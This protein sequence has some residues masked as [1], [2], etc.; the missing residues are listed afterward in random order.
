MKLP[1]LLAAC[2]A[3]SATHA[4]A[5]V[6]TFWIQPC[7]TQAA[8]ATA[9]APSDPD[10]ARWALADWAG[11]PGAPFTFQSVPAEPD[12]RLR[13]HWAGGA[14]GLYGEARE[15]D[16]HGQRGA[17]LYVLPQTDALGPA[18]ADAAR[19]DRLLREAIVYLTCLHESGHALGLAHTSR[20][21]DIMYSFQYGGDIPEYFARYRRRIHVRDDIRST[22]GVS[23][24]DRE[25]LKYVTP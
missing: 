25:M 11:Q 10:L 20:F 13:I 18:I 3:A 22:S 19:Q 12:A 21:E 5:E 17:V 7:T 23:P 9:C 1:L 24:H 15:I 14:D 16:F 6:W 2:F 4:G 8:S